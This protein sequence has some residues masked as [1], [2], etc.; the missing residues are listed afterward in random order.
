MQEL[1]DPKPPPAI[2]LKG[3]TKSFGERTVVSD[4]SLKLEAGEVFS[5]IGPS[6]AGKSTLIRC[7]NYLETPDNGEVILYGEPV[8]TQ[9]N[10]GGAPSPKELLKLRRQVGMVFQHFNLFPHMTAMENI[11]FPQQ[12]TKGTTKEEANAR[13]LELLTR[14][15][16]EKRAHAHPGRCSGGEQQRIAIARA[17][18]LDPSVMLFDEPTSSLDPE[19]GAEVLAVMKEL[20]GAGM[21]MIIVTHEMRFAGDVSDKIAVM[22]DGKVVEEGTPEILSSPRT[23]RVQK[24][25]NAV[26]DR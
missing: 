15:G 17:L 1:I 22:V 18:A 26:M 13:S 10:K 23:P 3:V 20:A 6:G 9:S 21:T 24:F 14:V 4:V 8:Q 11:S 7:V 25:L 2:A 12:R 5:L 19:V 16:L